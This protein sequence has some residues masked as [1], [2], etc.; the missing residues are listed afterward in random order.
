[1]TKEPYPVDRVRLFAL[2]VLDGRNGFLRSSLQH[3]SD[4]DDK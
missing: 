3:Y 4:K 2:A 1:M